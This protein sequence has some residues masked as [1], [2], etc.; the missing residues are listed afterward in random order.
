M[1][2]FVKTTEELVGKYC[3][4]GLFYT[5]YLVL[6]KGVGLRIKSITYRF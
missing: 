3:S 2:P 6:A 4:L 1:D 5:F